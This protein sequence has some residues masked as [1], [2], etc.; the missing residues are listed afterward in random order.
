MILAGVIAIV[1]L[2]IVT[3]LLLRLLE[4]LTPLARAQRAAGR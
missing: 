1:A 3:D 4:R 2:A